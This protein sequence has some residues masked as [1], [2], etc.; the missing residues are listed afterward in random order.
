MSSFDISHS[1]EKESDSDS[2][3]KIEL[4]YKD[5]VENSSRKVNSHSFYFLIE[6]HLKNNSC[7]PMFSDYEIERNNLTK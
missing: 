1:S 5:G 7:I 6:K 3:K 2:K 4:L